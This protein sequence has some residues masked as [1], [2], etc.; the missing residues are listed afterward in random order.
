MAAMDGSRV[1]VSVR[2]ERTSSEIPN[3]LCVGATQGCWDTPVAGEAL[4]EGSHPYQQPCLNSPKVGT[5][6]PE[7]Y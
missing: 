7:A 3:P 1:L 5:H 4:G 6:Q 2:V